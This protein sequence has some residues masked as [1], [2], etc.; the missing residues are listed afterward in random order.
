MSKKMRALVRKAIRGIAINR[1]QDDVP[2]RL[3]ETD[4]DQ[5]LDNI[6]AEFKVEAEDYWN[7]TVDRVEKEINEYLKKQKHQQDVATARK[8]NT[9]AGTHAAFILEG[10]TW[11]VL[12]GGREWTVRNTVGARCLDKLLHSP[13]KP[14]E[15]PDLLESIGSGSRKRGK[16]VGRATKADTPADARTV[17]EVRKKLVQLNAERNAI[18]ARGT[19]MELSELDDEITACEAYLAGTVGLHGKIRIIPSDEKKAGDNIRRYVN[20]CLRQF[21]QR[22]SSAAAAKALNEHISGHIRYGA[23]CEYDPPPGFIWG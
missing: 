9:T 3:T 22:G 15:S 14:I 18:S 17:A 5:F 8:L 4:R 10:A 12:F 2:M 20:R 1:G 19:Q 13:R 16:D 11:R 7:E 23:E 21:P 6:D